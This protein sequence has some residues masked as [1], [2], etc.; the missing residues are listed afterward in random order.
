MQRIHVSNAGLPSK[1]ALWLAT[2]LAKFLPFRGGVQNPS[3][4]SVSVYIYISICIICY[5][6]MISYHISINIYIYTHKLNSI[7][8]SYIH[9]IPNI[10]LGLFYD[11]SWTPLPQAPAAPAVDS[12][13]ICEL[14]D[15]LKDFSRRLATAEEEVVQVGEAAGSGWLELLKISEPSG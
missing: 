8:L 5:I 2:E 4:A 3:Y 11:T 12:L 1:L 14:V 7:K 13:R 9:C 10:S 6:N 15:S